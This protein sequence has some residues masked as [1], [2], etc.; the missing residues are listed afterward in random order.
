MY[1]SLCQLLRSD[2][3]NGRRRPVTLLRMHISNSDVILNFFVVFFA[4]IC[5]SAKNYTARKF[6]A[7]RYFII[8]PTH[9]ENCPYGCNATGYIMLR[10]VPHFSSA[11]YNER[12][13][14]VQMQT[15]F[16]AVERSLLSLWRLRSFWYSYIFIH[17]DVDKGNLGV[18]Y[19][20]TSS[21]IIG[22]FQRDL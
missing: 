12:V 3:A 13:A 5:Q 18:R 16:N 19:L 2:P 15:L 8:S 4:H 9:V 11:P 17:I 20:I 7:V 22:L 21:I 1:E 6:P 14:T 10:E